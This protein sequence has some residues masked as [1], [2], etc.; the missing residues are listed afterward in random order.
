MIIGAAGGHEILASL[1]FDA[2]AHRRH[3]AEPGDPRPRHRRASPTTP[4]TSPSNPS[5]NYVNGDGRSFL[6]RSDDDYDLDLVPGAR[7]LRGHERRRRR[8]RSC[9]PRA[10]STRARR[11]RRASSTS[12][13]TGSSPRSSASSNFDDEAEPHHPLREHGPRTRW[14]SSASRTRP[15]TSSWPPRRRNW[16]APRC[17]RSWSSATPFT[18]DEI[19]AVRRAGSTTIAGTGICSYAPGQ[20]DDNP[21]A[22]VVDRCRRRARRIG[23][24]S[25]PYDVGPITDDAPVL[26]ALRPLRRRRCATSATRSTAGVDLEDSIGERVLLLLLVRRRSLFAAVFLLLPFVAVR[27][28]W[29]AAPR[30]GTSALYFAALGLGFMFFEITLI[31]RLTL[32]LGYPTYSLTVTLASLLIFTGVGALLSER[33]AGARSVGAAGRSPVAIVPL[34]LFYCSGS[35]RSPTR[36]LRAA[37]RRARRD[38]VRRCSHRWGSASACSCRSGSARS[39]A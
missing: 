2:G 6:A 25:Y 31:Q 7:Q 9:S 13:P 26:L 20:P 15:S 29:S 36:C 21:V 16:P 4:A 8:A 30:K 23:T 33:L 32:F 18:D 14:T 10:T 38:R 35:R 3:R 17:R 12:P 1:Y 22:D 24:T 11:S 19:A 27:D 34:T 37:A 28:D 5:V 39:P